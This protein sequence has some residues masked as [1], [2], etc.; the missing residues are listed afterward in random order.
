MTFQPIESKSTATGGIQ[1]APAE[2]SLNDVEKIHNG[3]KAVIE[4]DNQSSDETNEN[5]KHS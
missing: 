4:G 3:M 5:T 1:K 2:R